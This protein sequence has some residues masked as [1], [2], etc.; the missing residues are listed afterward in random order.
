MFRGAALALA[1]IAGEILFGRVAWAD[2]RLAQVRAAIDA[3]DY[4][5][6]RAALVT[7]RDAGGC[8]PEETAA[9]YLL[10][11]RV[12]AALGDNQA[13]TDAFMHLLA[14]SP[15]ASLPPGMS[16]KISAPFDAA[17]AS[18]A[19]ERPLEV[20]VETWGAPPAI[21]LEVV[22]DPLHMVA[23]ARVVYA[24]EGGPEQTEE[25][26]VAERTEIPLHAGLRIAARVAVLDEH[27]NQLV[28]RGSDAPI[29]ITVAPPPVVAPPP[30]AVVHVRAVAR[31]IYV[32]WWPYAA[33]GV[34]LGGAAGYFAWSAYQT[35][36]DLQQLDRESTLHS[37]READELRDRGKRETLL[38]NI[39]FVAAGAF[40]VTAGVMAVVRPGS[41]TRMVAAPLPGGGALAVGGR[42]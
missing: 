18:L 35:A 12:E 8:T 34:V 14:L 40:A 4:L 39:G 3:S 7:V 11:G 20:R 41:E 37:W 30:P 36:S 29:V 27:G 24:V 16:P 17:V 25:V 23:H 15:K 1:V 22:S 10:S 32:R 26:A 5:A 6:A 31:P 9:L 19:L 21:L 33:A 42:F 2:D 28:E 38:A 13:A